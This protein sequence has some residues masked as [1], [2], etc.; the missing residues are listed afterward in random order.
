LLEDAGDEFPDLETAEMM[1]GDEEE[2]ES[3]REGLKVSSEKST[4]Q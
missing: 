3:A 2:A 4:D 1:E